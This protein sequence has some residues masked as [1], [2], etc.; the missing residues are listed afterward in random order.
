MTDERIK[1]LNKLG[2]D[3]AP[4]RGHL[5]E[6]SKHNKSWIQN[7]ESECA[8]DLISLFLPGFRLPFLLIIY[9]PLLKL[10]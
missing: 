8:K 2:F 10:L 6:E 1:A 9:L 3:W 4:G 5:T 7:L